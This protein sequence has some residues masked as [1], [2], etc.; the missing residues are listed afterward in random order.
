MDKFHQ[1]LSQKLT[2]A[3]NFRFPH[4]SLSSKPFAV[5]KEDLCYQSEIPI[6]SFLDELLIPLPPD[7]TLLPNQ[8]ATGDSQATGGG[9]SWEAAHEYHPLTV[10]SHCLPDSGTPDHLYSAGL[11]FSIVFL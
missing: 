1:E 3:R 10:S 5:V 9:G 6:L 8:Q 4:I 2:S 7:A 11:M